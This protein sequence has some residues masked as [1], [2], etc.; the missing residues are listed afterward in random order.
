MQS[1]QQLVR[2]FRTNAAD[3]TSPAYR[4]HQLRVEYLNPLFEM[5]GWDVTNREGKPVALKD[6]VHED[7][8]RVAGR[9]KAPDYGFRTDGVRRFFVEAKSPSVGVDDASSALQLRRYGWSAKLAVSVLTDFETL[10]LYDC[11]VPPRD[12]DGPEC[13]LLAQFGCDEFSDRWEDIRAL[14]SRRAVIE[15]S[16]EAFAHEKA[17]DVGFAPVDEAFLAQIEQWR[18]WLAKEIAERNDIGLADL[19]SAVQLIIDRIIFLRIAEDRGIETHGRLLRLCDG[20]GVYGRLID[21]FHQADARYNSGLFHFENSPGQYGAPDTTT[22][23]LHIS[24]AVLTKMLRGVYRPESPYEF[25]VMPAEIL[26]QVYEQFLGKVI[27][28]TSRG[29]VV[30]DKPEVKKAGG[31]YYTP[32]DVVRFIVEAAVTP[33]LSAPPLQSERKV[34]R[35]VIKSPLRVL[36]PACGSGS[37]LIEV[38]QHLLDWHLDWYLAHEPQKEAK[39]RNPRLIAIGPDDWR[40]SIAEKRRILLAHVYGVDIDPQAVEV[41]KLSLLLKMLEGE[42]SDRLAAQMDL[43]ETRVLPDLSPNIRCGNSLVGTDIIPD[44]SE[45]F[46]PDEEI[47]RNNPFEW[48]DEFPFDDLDGAFDVIVGN[49]PY[50][51]SEWMT[52]HWPHERRYCAERYSYASGNWDIF[53]AFIGKAADLLRPRGTL[54]MIVPNKLMTA[55]YASSVRRYLLERGQVELIRDYSAVPVFPVAVYPIVF[56]F[57]QGTTGPT[58]YEKVTVRTRAKT[59]VG[60]AIAKELRIDG[61]E[62]RFEGENIA[63]SSF[64]PLIKVARVNDAATVAEAYELKDLISDDF[65]PGE[66]D[67]KIVNSGTIDPYVHHWGEKKLRYLGRGLTHPVL[68]EADQGAYS[69][70]RVQQART[71]KILVANM[72]KRL[73]AIYDEDGKLLAAKSVNIVRPRCNPWLLLAILNSDFMSRYYEQKFHGRKL[74]G[75]YL[76]IAPAALEQLP[77]PGE[78]DSDT[79][80][81]IEKLVRQ[82]VVAKSQMPMRTGHDRTVHERHIKQLHDDIEAKVEAIYAPLAPPL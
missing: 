62:W 10:K 70:R 81:A 2:K 64:V 22:P 45:D 14:L 36:D 18:N 66:E 39:G 57:K 9:A 20:A 65:N 24:D 38:Y 80:K 31:V 82:L 48:E 4:E 72:T 41:T 12:E 35:K 6:V 76:Q 77:I 79:V 40:L 3:V 25:S 44:L 23:R 61:E 32:A 75:G 13:A 15:G 5:L 37:F 8:V 33:Y 51:D 1:V 26:G 21:V 11:R 17:E 74:S 55:R 27:R 53:C 60:D 67:L 7:A 54:S 58:S 68:L 50:I 29:A 52:K 78:I 69:A 56:A 47:L 30:E 34:G 42:S 28:L 59:A 63:G 43:F 46:A 71:P 73:E 19:N 49:P 16:L